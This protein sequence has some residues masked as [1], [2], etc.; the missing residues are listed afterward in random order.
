MKK[1]SAALLGAALLGMA[2]AAG[3]NDQA[4]GD[5]MRDSM[6]MM[7]A[8]HDGMISKNEYMMF[9]EKMWAQMKKDSNGLVDAKSMMMERDDMMK[10]KIAQ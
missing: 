7:D 1:I 6:K 8:N 5:A 2:L 3:A 4:M 9:H 10:D